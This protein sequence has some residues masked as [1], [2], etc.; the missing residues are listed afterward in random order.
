MAHRNRVNE[1]PIPLNNALNQMRNVINPNISLTNLRHLNN[2]T[3]RFECDVVYLHQQIMFGTPNEVEHFLDN[4]CNIHGLYATC[5]FVNFPL[6][7]IDNHS[8]ITALECA[9][10]WNTDAHMVRV[11]YRWGA[12]VHTPNIDGFFTN[13]RNLPPYRNYLRDYFTMANVENVNNYP[14]VEGLRERDEFHRVLRELDY[15][16][17]EVAAPANWQMPERILDRNINNNNN[18]NMVID[19][20]QY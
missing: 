8:N 6:Q 16:V 17:A 4:Y 7:D 2:T 19:D 15:I 12:N 18:N 13:D 1:A 5:M 14:P 20:N 11:L 9:L 3:P 10:T